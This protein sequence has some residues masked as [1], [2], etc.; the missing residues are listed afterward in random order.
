M[1][2]DS[3]NNAQGDSLI[4][5]IEKT[6]VIAEEV[7]NV[8]GYV[9]MISTASGAVRR[10]YA[11]VQIITGVALLIITALGSYFNNNKHL[12]ELRHRF[13]GQ[14]M[15]GLGNLT[16]ATV[17][18]VP[19]FGNITTMIYDNVMGCRQVYVSEGFEEI[20]GSF[21]FKKE[22]VNDNM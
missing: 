21:L 2:I 3:I 16:R 18:M 13:K 17:E 4:D 7:L 8:M 1:S 5:Y 10:I 6:E 20:I 12:Q 15:N 9:P 22:Q 14:I 11:M 19:F